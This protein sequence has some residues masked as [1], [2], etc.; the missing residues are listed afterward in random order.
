MEL[1][2]DIAIQA[3]PDHPYVTRPPGVVPPRPRRHDQ[4]RREPAEEVPGHLP[5]RLRRRRPRC[6]RGPVARVAADLRGLDRVA[7]IR[8]F[9]VDNPHTKPIAVLGMAHPRDPGRAPRGDLPVRGVHEA[10]DD[11]SAGEGRL[12]P[13]LHLL[14]LAR[15]AGRAA[16]LPHRADADRDAR[17]LPRQPVHQHAGHQP[18]PPRPR[19]PGLRDPHACW[20]RPCRAPYGIY[21]GWEL[22][23][24]ARLDEREEYLDSEKY[25]IRARDWDAPGN[26]KLLIGELNRLRHERPA[27]QRYDN[28]RFQDVTGERTLFYRKALPHGKVDPL[29]GHPNRWR[30]AVY[31]AVNTDPTAAERAILHPDLPAIGIGWDEPYRLTD[32]HDRSHLARARRRPAGRPRPGGGARSASSPSLRPRTVDQARLGRRPDPDDARRRRS[33]ARRPALVP[34]RDHL[35]APRQGVHATRPATGWATSPA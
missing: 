2:M 14:H 23:E 25:E 13:E 35:P 17:L 29:T 11:A 5:D 6:A 9:R 1:A 8:I 21:S 16:R 27:L 20:R 15:A 26:I 34:R 12:H 7:A 33:C 28:L 19:P 4:V 32:L 24:S 30:D 10:E 3:S 22:C 31:V 18:A